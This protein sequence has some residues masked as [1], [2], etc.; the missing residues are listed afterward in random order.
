MSRHFP[1]CENRSSML[2]ELIQQALPA[3][4]LGAATPFLTF[5][6]LQG[7]APVAF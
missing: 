1:C 3:L 6:T 4:W 2:V 5:I 7:M